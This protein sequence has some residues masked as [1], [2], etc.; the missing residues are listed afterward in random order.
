MRL[1]KYTETLCNYGTWGKRGVI[2]HGLITSATNISPRPPPNAGPL[3]RDVASPQSDKNEEDWEKE[4]EGKKKKEISLMPHR[5]LS[6][7][8][9]FLPLHS[10]RTRMGNTSLRSVRLLIWRENLVT[11]HEFWKEFNI[12]YICSRL[13]LCLPVYL[14]VLQKHIY[15]NVQ[16]ILYI[17]WILNCC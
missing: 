9:Q 17:F 3:G 4:T 8:R 2:N 12:L 6:S 16:F 15:R 13:T 1:R 7:L 10:W 5:H 11:F 14:Q